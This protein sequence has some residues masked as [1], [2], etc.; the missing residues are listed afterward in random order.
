[1]PTGV[2]RA[3]AAFA[4]LILGL[5]SV[6]TPRIEMIEV[7]AGRF[8]MGSPA[9]EAGRNADEVPH[10]VTI[11]R[12]F[13]IGKF[14]VTQEQWRTIMG[15]SPSSFSACGAAC[16]VESINFIEIQEFLKRV[17]AAGGELLYRLPTEAEWEYACRAGTTTPFST[18]ENLTTDQAD[19][20]G[21]FPYRG[22]PAGISREQ[23]TPAGTFASNR[24]GIADMHGNV[25]EWTSDWY[26]PYPPGAAI[27]PRGPEAGE[28]RVIRGGSWHFDANSARCALRYTHRPVDRGFSLGFRLAADRRAK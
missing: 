15:T 13:Y 24:W 26:A 11:T 7:S 8:T 18:G 23:P 19:Y 4:A 21:R 3:G 28:L 1:M 14:E 6:S 20:D 5:P 17:N 27:D 2:S 12:P 16:P 22:F 9:N 10:E 25:W